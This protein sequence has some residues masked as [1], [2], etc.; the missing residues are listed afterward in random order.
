SYSK[1]KKVNKFVGG[2]MH[3]LGGND[4]N[5]KIQH[6]VLHHSFTNIDGHDEDIDT[7]GLMRF[8]PNQE[9][10]S[11]HRFQV[12]Y[13]PILYGL[14]TFFWF[15][16]KDFLGLK[17]Y[18]DQDLIKTQATTY[19]TEVR[20]LIISRIFYIGVFLV[21]P[22]ALVNM[23]WWGTILGFCLMHFIA[24]LSLALIFQPA[25][26][27]TDTEF[28]VPNED[29]SVENHWAIH[30]M[31]TTANFANNS[32]AFTWFV[33]GLNHQV[34]HHLFPNVCHVHYPDLSKIVKA[35]AA[36]YDVPYLQEKTFFGA[37]R[38]HFTMINR[39]GKGKI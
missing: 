4:T 13:A 30:Q 21:L 29:L 22:I 37:L 39:L 8:S 24:G 11:M 31:K 9:R 35:T 1:N 3:I 38:S 16:A 33:G 34:E 2:V 5:W 28:V 20:K 17:R 32:K 36:E 26:V 27:I 23:A 18:Q 12:F 14:M 10:K 7:N 15:I 25:H 6:N 19:K